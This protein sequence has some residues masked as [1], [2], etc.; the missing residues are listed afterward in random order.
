VLEKFECLNGL[1]VLANVGLKHAF[2]LRT[3]HEAASV[4]N[5]L[6]EGLPGL[7]PPAR[8]EG[9]CC[10]RVARLSFYLVERVAEERE[11]IFLVAGVS[12]ANLSLAALGDLAH[13]RRHDFL[14]FDQLLED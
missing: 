2:K 1:E 8:Q 11:F 12:R 14:S 6:R 3:A 5:L 7:G 4:E 9:Q 10:I 13:S